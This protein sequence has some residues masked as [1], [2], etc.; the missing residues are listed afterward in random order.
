MCCCFFMLSAKSQNVT[1]PYSILGIGDM[2][3]RDAGRYFI[4]G[5]AALARRDETSYN[6]SNPAS[7]SS[8]PFKTIHFDMATKG[9]SSTFSF[10]GEDTSTGVTK[11]F[12][13]KRVTMA[14]KPTNKTGIAFGLKPYSSVN[15]KY[16]KERQILDGNS[17][18]TKNIDGNGG[19]NQFYASVGTSFGKHFSGGITASFLFGS[20]F[21]S[22]QYY[23]SSIAL[24][25]K[26]EEHDFYNGAHLL[27]GIQYYSAPGK[28]WKHTLGLTASVSTGLN[29]QLTSEYTENDVTLTKEIT[30]N[31]N[32]KL[33]ITAG[34]G[35]S[36][37]KNSRLTLSAEA[38]YY[39]WSYQKVEYS[40]SYTYPSARFSVGMDYSFKKNTWQRVVEKSFVGWGINIENS[41][42]RI[43]NQ[44]VWDYSFS[45]GGGLNPFN[46]ISVYSGIE[47][48]VRGQ[49]KS[50]LIR[51]AYTQ[52]IIGITIKDIW[53]GTKKYGRYN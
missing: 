19:I 51:E 24:D 3:T 29:G 14:F 42:L 53:I 46:N 4:S 43:K 16:K 36:A 20:L 44:K 6:F 21:R 50:G 41:Y 49:K 13:I 45:L 15:Y 37:T 31:R 12:V 11:D 47:L 7:L 2:D 39:H 23:S 40:N 32:F 48:G 26:K 33:P 25:I 22:T 52:Y 35:Y 10:P 28:K 30:N 17:P 18:Y 1:S 38:N 9:R 8:L 27:T 34:F 5:N